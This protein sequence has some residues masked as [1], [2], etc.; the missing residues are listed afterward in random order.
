M[1][2]FSKDLGLVY[3]GLT[4][5]LCERSAVVAPPPETTAPVLVV[6]PPEGL[7]VY[8][9]VGVAVGAVV[10]V[11]AVM[12]LV[13][14]RVRQVRAME[15]RGRQEAAVAAAV[16]AIDD[17]AV[18]SANVSAGPSDSSSESGD[19]LDGRESMEDVARRGDI[20]LGESPEQQRQGLFFASAVKLNSSVSVNPDTESE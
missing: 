1:E 2:C 18:Q 11:A 12:A 3:D 15:T 14:V 4:T 16:A 5:V 20:A 6:P 7:S 19:S 9:I 17:G 13:L 10:L 8:V